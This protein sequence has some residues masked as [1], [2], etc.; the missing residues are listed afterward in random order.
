MATVP[1]RLAELGYRVENEAQGLL[2]KFVSP[3]RHIYTLASLERAFSGWSL[4]LTLL[5][6]KE[7]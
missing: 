3:V 6:L 1:L 4:R 5:C 2:R 7:D